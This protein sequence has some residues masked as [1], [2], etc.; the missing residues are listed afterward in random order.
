ML[1]VAPP[2][3]APSANIMAALAK[4][5]EDQPMLSGPVFGFDAERKVY[6]VAV[7]EKGVVVHWQVECCH[8]QAEADGNKQRYRGYIGEMLATMLPAHL[9]TLQ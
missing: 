6:L 9:P 7:V 4:V 2:I 8:D 5:L 1:K 3:Q